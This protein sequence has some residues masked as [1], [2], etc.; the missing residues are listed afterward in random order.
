MNCN[1]LGAASALALAAALVAPAHAQSGDTGGDRNTEIVVTAERIRGQVEAPQAPI[2]VLEE[3][4]IASYGVASL[5]E[6]IDELAPQTGSARG[7]G[8]GRPAFLVNGRRVNGFREMRNYPPEAIRRVEILPEEVALRYGFRPDQRVVNFILKDNFVSVSGDVEY[9]FPS[10]GG[11][12]TNE[13]E[14]SFLRIDGDNRLNIAFEA[15]DSSMLTEAERDVSSVSATPLTGWC[16]RARTS[17]PCWTKRA[18]IWQ[19]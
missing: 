12:S 4:E 3:D 18:T 15:E 5:A 19:R 14:G 17:P 2:A 13:I 1:T 10:G 8:G 11:Y 16:S 7:R 6:L 9:G